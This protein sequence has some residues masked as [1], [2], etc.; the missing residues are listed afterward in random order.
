[1]PPFD[2]LAA[3]DECRRG[4]CDAT[5]T[6]AD[7][8]ARVRHAGFALTALLLAL[9]F[10][11]PIP[12]GPFSIAAGLAFA[13]LGLQILRGRETLWLPQR[14]LHK[15]LH[16]R[17]WRGLF[18]LLMRVMR[19]VR[20]IARP[21]LTVLTRSAA[22]QRL[23]GLLFIVN[24][25]LLAAPLVFVPFGNMMPAAAI[26]LICIA[27]LEQDGLLAALAWLWTAGVVVLL[28]VVA[29]GLALLLH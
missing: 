2:A 18:S 11:Q 13:L 3:L 4:L 5:F 8:L 26:V 19:L 12:L 16:G 10:L 22:A 25:L 14:V 1:M 15:E 28:L 6:F 29:G 24:G 17:V 23:V 20:R 9:P 7:I 27:D 21:R